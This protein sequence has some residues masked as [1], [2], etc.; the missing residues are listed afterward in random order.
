MAR[1][2]VD[3]DLLNLSRGRGKHDGDGSVRSAISRDGLVRMNQQKSELN[4]QVADAVH[5]IE[6]LRQ[7][8]DDLEREKK[9][10]EEL[11]RKQDDYASTKKEIIERISG[12]IVILEKEEMQAARLLELYGVIKNKYKDT[13]AELRSISEESWTE[14]TYQMELNKAIV[15]VEDAKNTYQKGIARMEAAGWAQSGA[16]SRA[17]NA[18]VQVAAQLN[19]GNFR[20]WFRVGL[21][22]SIPLMMFGAV[23]FVLYLLFQGGLFG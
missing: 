2:F 1:D 5:E 13:L 20:Y 9:E 4:H 15:I 16:S 6:E 17:V 11:A 8:Q 19:S 22:V 12:S 14:D 23:L 21:A 7:R 18:P 10:L 3:D